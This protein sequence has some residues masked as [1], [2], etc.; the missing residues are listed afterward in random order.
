MIVHGGIGPV[1]VE[2]QHGDGVDGG[3]RALFRD[4]R[5]H[6][7]VPFDVRAVGIHG[8]QIFSGAVGQVHGHGD[9]H[10][11]PCG[12]LKIPFADGSQQ[13]VSVITGNAAAVADVG[14]AGDPAD[15]AGHV[16][17]DDQ[18][19]LLV[20]H[21]VAVE[22]AAVRFAGGNTAALDVEADGHAKA[23]G[24]LVGI[25]DAVD[26]NRV[27]R[28]EIAAD[29]V[30]PG[31][32]AE[33]VQR[34][35]EAVNTGAGGIIAQLRLDLPVGCAGVCVGGH[36]QIGVGS[37]GVAHVGKTGALLHHGAVRF[38]VHQGH[39]GGHQQRGRQPAGG[40]AQ[41]CIQTVFLDVLHD[42]S[43]HTGDLRRRHGRAGVVLVSG[44]GGVHA[45]HG[46]DITA[47]RG[48]F[49]LDLQIAGNAPGAEITH[50]VPVTDDGGLHLVGDVHDAPVA[51][52]AAV[53]GGNGGRGVTQPAPGCQ[54]HGN[55]GSGVL[56]AV[57]VHDQSAFDVVVNDCGDKACVHGVGR[58]CAEVDP[59]PGT[60]EHG[61]GGNGSAVLGRAVAVDENV[62]HVAR[63]RR[64]GRQRRSVGENALGIEQDFIAQTDVVVGKTD[65]VN[66]SD[67]HGTGGGGGGG[68]HAVIHVLHVQ[69]AGPVDRVVRPCAGVA[70]S[71]GH[72]DVVVGQAVQNILIDAVSAEAL[73]GPQRQVDRVA[74]QHDGVLD[75]DHVVG[76]IGAA[77][78]SEHLHDD[79]LRVGR[80][81]LHVYL[82]QRVGI[83]AVGGGDKAV[84]GGDTGN[85]GTVV[86]HF[87]AVMVHDV[88]GIHVIDREGD[89]F[90]DV[91]RTAR[92]AGQVL[93]VRVHVQP[94][95]NVG[96]VLPAQQIQTVDVFRIADAF[97][98]GV[99]LQ[100]IQERSVVKALVIGIQ[101]G[102][103]D[104]DPGTGAGV[105]GGP[106]DVGA[107]HGGGGGHHRI[108]GIGRSLQRVIP[109]FRENVP[110]TADGRDL[111]HLTVRDVGR[112]DIGGQGHGPD[113]VQTLP[114]KRFPFDPGDHRFLLRLQ[115][116]AVRHGGGIVRH[117]KCRINFQSRFFVQ[118]DGNTDDVGIRIGIRRF[119]LLR[120]GCIVKNVDVGV[121]RPGERKPGSA[122]SAGFGGCFGC[123]HP[124][125]ICRDDEDQCKKYG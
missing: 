122:V 5:F 40:N 82:G 37:D 120:F 117:V 17:Q 18:S 102:V 15:L 110:D 46:V 45:V 38:A 23:G 61:V 115:L 32:A 71:H 123:G 106:C 114:V 25:R 116:I 65:I 50:H 69:Q 80:H 28:E 60:D 51:D 59:A 13:Q 27:L 44:A 100:R 109:V 91:I 12:N 76:F 78:T 73:I 90:T 68:N 10:G 49:G 98:L 24:R 113:H 101:T 9:G 3:V 95:Q 57:H 2:A 93:D 58:L 67:G 34:K 92:R 42:Q 56:V 84:G 35:A 94:G 99:L 62:V 64:Q 11:A 1:A 81:A 39:G 70:G 111:F 79:D 87:V 89:F 75:G 29:A 66:G 26:C 63:Q 103:D 8:V 104:R 47:G 96:D 55:G 74:V 36:P 119:L 125:G 124:D 21:A 105:S 20:G 14:F 112:N 43:G 54:T 85:V 53:S 31:F 121:V 33:V 118:N 108:R 77:G 97:F 107:D 6:K 4:Q 86:A 41:L 88:I 7:D 72:D 16:I 52:D 22:V 48:E 83:T 19:V 30:D